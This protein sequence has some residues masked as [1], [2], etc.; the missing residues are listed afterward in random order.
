M[1]S[2]SVNA[3]YT[4]Q[5]D[6]TSLLEY[7]NSREDIAE[8]LNYMLGLQVIT[9][10]S[11]GRPM[12]RIVRVNRPLFTDEY[13]RNIVG[14]LRAFLNFTIQVTRFDKREIV[15][16]V[17]NYLRKL[18]MSLC[19]HGD[20]AYISELT[21]Q[22][23]L[24]IHESEMKDN[25]P[26]GWETFDISWSYDDP[27]N[28]EM[29]LLVKDFNEERDQ[30]VEFDRI[31]SK[32]SSMIHASFNKSFSPNDTTAGMLLGSMKEIRTESQVIREKDGKRSMFSAFG[33]SE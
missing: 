27:V 22:K 5:Q 1:A 21:W 10:I 15:L 8:I 31:V 28:S 17:S 18:V 32:F 24:D 11:G 25:K 16:K 14:D 3:Q 29:V 20:D 7:L 26:A 2:E 4:Q 19:T 12:Q 13:T 23:I 30:A 33:R 9:V 6:N